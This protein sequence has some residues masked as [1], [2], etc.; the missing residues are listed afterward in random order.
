V[1][2]IP[3]IED[4]T[5]GPVHAGSNIYVEFEPSSQWYNASLTIAAGWMRS[6]G[7]ASYNVYNHTPDDVRSQL[8]RLGLDVEALEK[9]GKFRIIDWYTSQLGQKSKEKYAFASLK[10]ADL[11]IIYSRTLIQVGSPFPDTPAPRLGPDVLRLSDDDLVLLRF[12]DERSFLDFWRTRVIPSAQARNSTVIHSIAKG[13]CSEYIYR[14]LETSADGI[15]EVK[16]DDQGGEVRNLI[17]I[18]S[19]RNMSYDSR[20]HPLKLDEKFEVTLEN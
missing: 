13:V 10:I 18:R 19:M 1:P 4:L 6:D 3:L 20:W 5:K 15:I 17:R 11:S 2:R 7:M 8:E 14:N 12:N 16:V 9:G